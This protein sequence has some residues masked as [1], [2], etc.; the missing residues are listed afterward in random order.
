MNKDDLTKEFSTKIK[1][2]QASYDANSYYCLKDL[3]E[4]IY[5]LRKVG[6]VD[7]HYCLI[8]IKKVY[9]RLCLLQEEA[10]DDFG[11]IS[12]N[13]LDKVKDHDESANLDQV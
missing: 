8:L 11:Y 6:Q 10:F 13:F 9:E 2:I 3:S 5:S 1:A 12:N 7:G 4:E